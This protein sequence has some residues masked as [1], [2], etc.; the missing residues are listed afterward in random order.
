MSIDL[1]GAHG[2]VA[3]Q[4]LDGAKI[5]PAL[6]K[7]GG[8]RMTEGMRRGPQGS[9]SLGEIPSQSPLHVGG[10]ERTAGTAYEDVIFLGR[11]LFAQFGT[12]LEEIAI[13][14]VKRDFTHRHNPHFASLSFYSDFAGTDV[15]VPQP[16]IQNLLTSQ[17]A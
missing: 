6:E 17:P 11:S 3:E 8:E 12:G 15:D 13:E 10:R 5:G 16:E 2:G 7:V 1:S 4:F 9:P 14:R